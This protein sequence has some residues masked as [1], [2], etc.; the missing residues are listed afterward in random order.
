MIVA[1]DISTKC[2][3]MTVAVGG[4]IRKIA[5]IEPDPVW[6]DYRKLIDMKQR[7]VNAVVEL[8]VD[9]E[10]FMVFAE[11][12]F[13][14]P[15][16]SHPAP[17]FMLHGMILDGLFELAKAL[18]NAKFYWNVVS[19]STWRKWLLESNNVVAESRK[20]DDQKE[21]TFKALNKLGYKFGKE[22]SNDAADSL[23]IYLWAKEQMKETA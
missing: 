15:G 17:M 16:K 2:T 11:E 19:V 9:P 8:N 22:H 10:E 18:N 6:T 14:V 13:F 3:G 4:G 21:A 20:S 5:A 12:P 1:L 7:V 23:G